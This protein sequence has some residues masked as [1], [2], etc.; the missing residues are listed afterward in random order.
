MFNASVPHVPSKYLG[1]LPHCKQVKN[2]K[3]NN[4]KKKTID[5]VVIMQYS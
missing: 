2:N 3:K 4:K 5:R 1:F